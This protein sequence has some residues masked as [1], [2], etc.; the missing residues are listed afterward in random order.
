M[1]TLVNTNVQ[2]HVTGYMLNVGFSPENERIIT[3]IQ[4]EMVEQ[5]GDVLW[6]TPPD[7][8]HITL[9]DWI[10]PLVDYGKDKDQ[11]FE[12]IYADYDKVIT[13][14]LK[15]EFVFDVKFGKIMAGAAAV[16]MV[17]YDNGGFERIRK[18][19]LDNATLLP[20]TKLPPQIIHST[21]GRFVKETDLQPIG[22]Y[23]ESLPVTFDQKV[24][25]FRLVK[26]TIDPMLEFEVIKEYPLSE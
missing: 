24:E 4:K 12:Q 9:L 16:F 10:A 26:E 14:A 13:D 19:Y 20:N 15:D 25:K 6:L 18:K 17:G 3:G 23:V 2:Q 1:K 21:L 5:F 7:A 22:D 11:L 8:L